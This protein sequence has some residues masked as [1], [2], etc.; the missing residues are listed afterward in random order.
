MS[1]TK[2]SFRHRKD[3]DRRYAVMNEC[4]ELWNKIVEGTPSIIRSH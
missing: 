3:E 4:P 2:G 1:K